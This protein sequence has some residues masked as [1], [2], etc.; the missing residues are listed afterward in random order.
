MLGPVAM[1]DHPLSG[2]DQPAAVVVRPLDCRL[3]VAGL[4]RRTR[5]SSS[6]VTVNLKR[7]AMEPSSW[8][9]VY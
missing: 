1:T 7:L 8:C 6:T 5:I 4:S 3:P 2:I 9:R